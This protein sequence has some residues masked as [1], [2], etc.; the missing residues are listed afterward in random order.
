MLAAPRLTHPGHLRTIRR[1]PTAVSHPSSSPASHQMRFFDVEER[2][3][4]YDRSRVAIW[5]VPLEHSVSYGHGAAGG[6]EAILVASQQVEL[7]DE[8]LEL[9]PA[10]VGIATLPAFQAEHEEVE[11]VLEA[12]E[13][14]AHAHL[15]AGKFLLTLG[16]EH[17]LTIG[18]VR[19][20]HRL[21]EEIGVV[22]F[23]AHADLRDEYGGSPW[24]HA[25][26]MRRI[27][28]RGIPTLGVGIRALS[29]AEAELIRDRELPVI[30]GQELATLDRDRFGRLLDRLPD[31]VYLT[32][33]V[34]F[35]DPAVLPSTGTPEPGG[36]A[37]YPTLELL[38]E[39]F[40]RKDVVAADV[41]ELAP[42]PGH[43]ASDF[44][45][46]RLVYKLIGLLAGR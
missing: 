40:S 1:D 4:H 25:C 38:A 37:W 3:A 19:A 41:V 2:L 45:V 34:D 17:S 33:D 24:S 9:E 26:V 23:D 8:Q 44:V 21:D 14:T 15:A 11:A 32:F 35:F 28:E 27:V 39:L 36:G 10:S 5:P 42:V 30:W 43:P 12:I 16:G 7:Y 13:S 29:S 20:A 31:R 18:P 22:Q 46:A 6:P